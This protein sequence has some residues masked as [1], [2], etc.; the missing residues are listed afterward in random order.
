M[1][2]DKRRVVS[3]SS[4]SRRSASG[5]IAA[6]LLVLPLANFAFQPKTH[7]ATFLQQEG[8]GASSQRAEKP[9]PPAAGEQQR[10]RTVG[11]ALTLA[12]LEEMALR[13][14]PTLAQ[15]EAAI[16][17]AEGRRKQ[18]GLY[19][20]PMV[21][22]RGEEFAF[23]AFTDK[24][25]HFFFIEQNIVTGGKLS[26]GKAVFAQEK[27]QAEAE[28]E[29]QKMRVLN[30]VRLLYYEALGAHDL[31][32]LR[33]QL[34]KIANEAVD[35]SE[36]LFNIGQADRP[37]LLEAEIEAQR[38]ELDL[39]NAENDRDHVWQLLA[40]V[41]GDKSLR[42]GPLAGDIDRGIPTLDQESLLSG[43]LQAS[44]EMKR[45][46]AGVERARAAVARAKAD[47]IPDIFVRGGVGY[48]TEVQERLNRPI[49]G[50]TGPEAS[51]E[52]GVRLPLFNRNQGNIA[53]AEADLTVAEREVQR[54]ELALLARF[55]SAFRSYSNSLRVAERYRETVLPRAQRAHEVYLASFKQMAAAYPQVL[56]AQRTMFQ[57]RADYVTALVN[58][59]QNA[60]RIQGYLLTG[61]LDA[62]GR[63]AGPEASPTVRG[64]GDQ[65]DR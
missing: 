39:V 10:E 22:Y 42:P 36:E 53:A 19:P 54:Q 29:A 44:P 57:V 21:G 55:A 14:N 41:V 27:A 35:I 61:G 26:K 20:N 32:E 1:I 2:D 13:N 63:E 34:A 51:V 45:A 59:W 25:E 28:A 3:S 40:A 4:S 16:R 12:Q 33:G 52:I 17:A 24:S 50:R 46:R 62:P 38:A 60:V 58:V 65:N 56:I 64:A 23:R 9:S 6:L 30:T 11:S 48:S 15:A 37:D 43:L 49:S 31:V 47:P 7:A 8:G 18:A 5:V